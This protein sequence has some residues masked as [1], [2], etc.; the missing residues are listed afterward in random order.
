MEKYENDTCVYLKKE[1]FF[2]QNKSNFEVL[3]IHIKSVFVQNK[4]VIQ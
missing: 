2:E 1:K 4:Q 3:K